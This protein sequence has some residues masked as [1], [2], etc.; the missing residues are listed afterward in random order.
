MGQC[1]EA[2]PQGRAIFKRAC[3]LEAGFVRPLQ[4]HLSATRWEALL[5]AGERTGQPELRMPPVTIDDEQGAQW[6]TMET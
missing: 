5:Y 3:R 4:G 6:L 2:R 1:R